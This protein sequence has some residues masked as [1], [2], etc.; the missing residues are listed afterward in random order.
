M[1]FGYA[2]G[3]VSGVVA[4]LYAA[5]FFSTNHSW[6]IYE[7]INLNKLMVAGLGIVANIIII[8]RLQKKWIRASGKKYAWKRKY[9]RRSPIPTV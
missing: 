3:I 4:F 9:W 7:M 2:A 5:F 8:G 6:F 1:Q